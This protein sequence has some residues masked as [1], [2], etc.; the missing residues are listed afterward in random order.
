MTQTAVR[1]DRRTLRSAALGLV[2]VTAVWGSTFGMSKDL[3]ER[4]PVTDYLGPRFLIAALALVLV[5]PG[6]LRGLDRR[7]MRTG[8]WLGL[9]YAGAQLLQYEGLTRT[10]PTVAAFVV[11]MYVVFTPLLVGV[12]TRSA[13]DRVT[14]IA[15]GL[16]TFG[17]AAMSLRGWALGVGE[18]IT[19]VSAA[20]YAVH[21][22]ALARWACPGEA[23]PLT[24]VQLVA[25]GVCLT[26]VA[27][28][29]GLTV[30]EA[31]DV[32]TFLYLAVLAAAL[33]L[34]VQTWAQARL[35]SSHAAVLMV[36]EPV[37]AA[38]FGIVVWQES[39]ELRTFIGGALILAAMLLVVARPEAEAV[40]A[41]AVPAHP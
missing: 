4:M 6:L 31:S 40:G 29:D 3:L 26:A 7:T 36:L 24:F 21:I 14:V 16:A 9:L 27:S 1:T 23:F 22:L 20:V 34:L 37:W 39:L 25:M 13:P 11:S 8:T 30:P 28:V 38:A 19:V 32:P 17:V 41:T 12:L 2:G 5:R 18:A 35:S 15:T 33:V 10:A